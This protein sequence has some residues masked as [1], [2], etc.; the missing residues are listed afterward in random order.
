MRG[1]RTFRG[2]RLR[3]LR[4]SGAALC[5]AGLAPL[6]PAQEWAQCGGPLALPE[7]PA[8]LA[9]A[10][11][12][13][14]ESVHMEAD[15]AD[16]S[17][18][19]RSVLTG[20]VHLQRGSRHL[21]TERLVYAHETGEASADGGVKFWDEGL[22]VGAERVEVEFERERVLAE[23]ARFMLREAH[24]R[25]GAQRVR[26]EDRKLFLVE[27]GRYTTCNPGEETWVLEAGEIEID[28]ERGFGVARNVWVRIHRV[29]VFYTPFLSFPLNEERRSGLLPSSA[30][31]SGASGLEVDAS[32]YFNLAPNRDAT[33]AVRGLQRR[34]VQSA[35][36]YRY[37]MPWGRGRLAGEYMPDDRKYDGDRG[38]LAF[39][40]E[41]TFASRWSADLDYQWVSDDRYLA[42]F[43]TDLARA[44]RTHLPRRAD[45]AYSGD[46]FRVRGRMQD[47]QILG[48]DIASE[49]LPYARL[50]QILA[51]TQRPER[52]RRLNFSAAAELAR[53]ERDT[54]TTGTR[55]D[56]RSSLFYPWRSSAG[57]LVPKLDLRLTRYDLSGLPSGA[58]RS[59][60]RLLP[61]VSV[62]GGLV[63]ERELRFAER[64]L[65]QT[66]EPRAYYLLV[67]ARSQS[68]QPLFDTG[69]AS[70]DFAQLFRENRFNGADRVGDANQ[71]TL[72]LSTRLLSPA[73]G[74]ELA[75]AG[76]G[77]IHYFRDRTVTLP[78]M[79]REV[80]A[81]SHLV[82]EGMLDLPDPWSLHGTL[83]WDS[84]ED[85][86]SRMGAALRYR[87]E[88]NRVVNAA[89]RFL[90]AD[91]A[92][93]Q[94]EELEQVDLS[95]AWPLRRSW[96]AI[97]RWNYALREG[98]NI[99]SFAGLE[100]DGCC[101]AIR[102]GLRRHLSGASGE[103]SSAL[104]LNFELKGLG[105]AGSGRVDPALRGI[106]G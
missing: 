75:R 30:R 62:D 58:E 6:A 8:P 31:V 60:S 33:L 88:S 27:D 42:D 14:P 96:R 90:R 25:G 28:R 66:L 43:G 39:R 105:G 24:A 50:P 56:L 51:T 100:Y 63:F 26:L 12:G 98:R 1:Q 45:F 84:R 102:T 17:Q 89:Y 87:S 54:G 83:H 32:Y 36:E 80:D 29:P 35:A 101:L 106:G 94:E 79:A 2:R 19:E 104:F 78:G 69:Y 95:F 22:F 92:R 4:V 77:Q 72:A 20:N 16:R 11:L 64:P 13:N 81:S 5:L 61:L 71:L 21:K 41:G 23:R 76:I 99:E 97:G 46:G 85:E 15:A 10:A 70:F 91:P 82:G 44:A 67:P 38:A 73:Q 55:M 7:A 74:R 59:P 49:H 18:E 52:N 65:V 37:L 3:A 53:F 48:D 93:N 103:Y 34:G 57:F 9:G 86:A 47:Y 40:H 68:D